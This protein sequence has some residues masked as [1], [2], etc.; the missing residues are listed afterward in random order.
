[1]SETL[2]SKVLINLFLWKRKWGLGFSLFRLQASASCCSNHQQAMSAQ[3]EQEGH[4]IAAQLLPTRKD[5]EA[6]PALAK[7]LPAIT[8]NSSAASFSLHPRTS[9]TTMQRVL[10]VLRVNQLDA[11]CLDTEIMDL[12]KSQFT[13]IFTFWKVSDP[14][15]HINVY[16]Q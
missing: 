8:A 15:L 11:I 16:S 14:I 6:I 13:K 3:W 4:A 12:L 2:K 10:H 5:E 7:L 9:L 1:M